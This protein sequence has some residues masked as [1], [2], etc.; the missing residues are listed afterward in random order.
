MFEHYNMQSSRELSTIQVSM[1]RTILKK[2]D[3]DV[4]GKRLFSEFFFG[5][6]LTV[7]G[8]TAI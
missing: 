7:G 3:A 1:C 8:G 4:N 6:L 2:D 5:E